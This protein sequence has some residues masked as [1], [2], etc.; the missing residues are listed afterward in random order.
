MY[1]LTLM[2]DSLRS[3]IPIIIYVLTKMTLSLNTLQNLE[4]GFFNLTRTDPYFI[5]TKE[6]VYEGSNSEIDDF[7]EH[8]QAVYK[9]KHIDNHINPVWEPFDIS[10]EQLCSSDE[11]KRLRIEIWDFEENGVDRIVG[12]LREP[13]TLRELF[14][15]KSIRGNADKSV[16]LEIVEIDSDG[17]Q[18][19]IPAGLV[20]V[21][22]AERFM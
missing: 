2:I 21:L 11:T 12:R 22:E 10:F 1:T 20:V 19:T 16:A 3:F 9:S 6:H 4:K 18:T 17:Y 5:I 13:T 14:E 15:R 8:W 7:D